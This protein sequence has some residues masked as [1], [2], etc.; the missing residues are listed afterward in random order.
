[1]VYLKSSRV[2]TTKITFVIFPNE[3]V[4]LSFMYYTITFLKKSSRVVITQKK[5]KSCIPLDLY[6][7][8]TDENMY[9]FHVRNIVSENPF[10]HTV[11]TFDMVHSHTIS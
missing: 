8:S 5:K 9:F 6:T 3:A 2:I 10:E 1:M 7:K 11:S 4:F